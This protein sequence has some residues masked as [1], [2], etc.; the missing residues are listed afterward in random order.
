MAILA[1]SN[2]RGLLTAYRGHVITK[3]EIKFIKSLQ[4]KKNR[5]E[6]SLFFVEGAK[7]VLE[8]LASDFTVE[9]VFATEEFATQIPRAKLRE[10][11]LEICPER[12]LVAMGTFESNNAALALLQFKNAAPITENNLTLLLDDI[13]D[14]GNLGTIIRTA[15]WFGIKDIVCSPNTTDFYSPKVINATM[16]SFTRINLLYQDLNVFLKQNKRTVY[17]AFLEGTK[18]GTSALERNSVLVIGNEAKG[19]S[20]EV[21]RY[22]NTKVTIPGAGHTESLNASV[23]AAILMYALVN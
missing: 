23:A 13:S 7:S 3:N 12:D 21:E 15:D 4:L 19:I 18:L 10:F 14:P 17:G 5:Q 11:K 1:C 6:H 22:V 9:K 20:K 8:A 2:R 16:G